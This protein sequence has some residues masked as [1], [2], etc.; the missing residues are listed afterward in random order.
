MG[1]SPYATLQMNYRGLVLSAAESIQAITNLLTTGVE[2]HAPASVDKSSDVPGTK[3]LVTAGGQGADVRMADQAKSG[4]ASY[5]EEE[6]LDSGSG[7]SSDPADDDYSQQT[8]RRSTRK[9][10]TQW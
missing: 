10:V 4:S 3:V 7:E 9:R 6:V 5:E 8:V 1:L 2:Q